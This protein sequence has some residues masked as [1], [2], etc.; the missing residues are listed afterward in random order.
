MDTIIFDV[1]DTLYDQAL[2][3]KN[4]CNKV[5]KESLTDDELNALYIANRK[6]SDA[7]FDEKVAGKLTE[8]EMH[9]R[10]IKD[11][12][13]EFGIVMNDEQAM[14]FQEAYVVEQNKIMLF[15]E[16]EELL[17]RLHNQGKQLAILTNGAEGH[18]SMKINQ[19]N[20]ER[21]IPKENIFISGA[22]GHAKPAI[23]V[24]Q[25]IES[26]LGLDR[27]KTVY[28]GDSFANDIVGAKQAGWHAVWMNHRR[29]DSLNNTV[30]PDKVVYSAREMLEFIGDLDLVN[31]R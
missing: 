13:A 22:V 27:E 20:L 21:W 30:T 25:I 6:H 16:V 3:F 18:Q 12:C 24:F 14:E 19:L 26:K 8:R 15:D 29:R 17:E 5:L 10:R 11:A 23:E 7:L 31:E 9:I 4:T 1:D 28:V 2:S